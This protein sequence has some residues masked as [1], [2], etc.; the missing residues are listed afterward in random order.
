MAKAEAHP[1]H[2][3]CLSK[4]SPV[5]CLSRLAAQSDGTPGT[6]AQGERTEGTLHSAGR[7]VPETLAGMSPTRSWA[8]P[9]EKQRP[10]GTVTLRRDAGPAHA[11]LCVPLPHRGLITGRQ[12]PCHYYCTIVQKGSV[13]RPRW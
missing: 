8:A 7:R 10:C 11:G 2:T 1:Y 3:G 12:S 13:T 5:A 9:Q 6:A 4:A